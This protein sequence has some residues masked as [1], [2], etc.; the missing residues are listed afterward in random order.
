MFHIINSSPNLQ[1]AFV[2]QGSLT[3][4]AHFLIPGLQ[5]AIIVADH[6][7]QWKLKDILLSSC[8][9]LGRWVNVY[10]FHHFVPDALQ[11]AVNLYFKCFYNKNLPYIYNLRNCVLLRG[12]WLPCVMCCSYS[13]NNKSYFFVFLF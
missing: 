3:A 10:T 12:D 7:A 13:V 1:F 11:Y 4:D 6:D 9:L 5:K 2:F 8:E